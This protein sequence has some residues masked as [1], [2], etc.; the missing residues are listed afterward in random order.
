MFYN[1]LNNLPKPRLSPPSKARMVTSPRLAAE[2]ESLE[3]LMD[4][5]SCC[6][7]PA[8]RFLHKLTLWYFY[9]A[10]IYF[11]EKVECQK[12]F[13]KKCKKTQ[14]IILKKATV[15]FR[16]QR[17]SDLLKSGTLELWDFLPQ[18]FT[19]KFF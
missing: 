14:N 6:A 11:S 1:S 13:S 8:V 12:N 2:G 3:F 18:G 5:F 17:K 19:T 15:L 10:L 7:L 9:S 4:I 16:G